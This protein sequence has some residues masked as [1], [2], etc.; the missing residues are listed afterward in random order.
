MVKLTVGRN[1]DLAAAEDLLREI[2]LHSPGTAIEI[3]LARQIRNDFFVD[4]RLASVVAT[5][6]DR[7]KLTV[8][9]WVEGWTSADDV[10][11]RFG[12]TL[13]GLA[14]AVYGREVR[15][16]KD[17]GNG[18]RFDRNE[19]VAALKR[20]RGM[21]E[22]PGDA[23]AATSLTIGAVDT[24]DGV[25]EP[26]LLAGMAV[27]EAEPDF[28]AQL[29][30]LWHKRLLQGTGSKELPADFVREQ[31]DLYASIW[32]LYTN[33]M[34]YG[35]RTTGSLAIPGLRFLRLRRHKGPPATLRDRARGFPTLVEYLQQAA[36]EKLG[37][38]YCE[39]TVSDHGMG[40]LDRYYGIF[41]NAGQERGTPEQRRT[42]L[43]GL[44]LGGL[45]E[46]RQSGAGWGI[47]RALGAIHRLRGFAAIRTGEFWW[48]Y[49]GFDQPAV[50]SLRDVLPG[51]YLAP[52]RGTHYNILLPVRPPLRT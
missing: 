13:D 23:L 18:V 44:I 5:A 12:R 49:S 3:Y 19:I 34:L 39:V 26:L 9:D 52:I 30:R 37:N 15:N 38:D 41:P 45:S 16:T 7:H 42:T 50:N 43:R 24:I 22:Q 33:S 1:F 2:E 4:G 35:A 36:A 31:T 17:A 51:K 8:V 40:L 11:A 32:E 10:V 27:R 20:A 46:S 6:A 29:E 14:A 47:E 48:S 28:V 25:T 21:V